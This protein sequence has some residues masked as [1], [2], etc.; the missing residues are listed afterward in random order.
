MFNFIDQTKCTKPLPNGRTNQDM[1][2]IPGTKK[3]A[4]KTSCKQIVTVSIPMPSYSTNDEDPLTI[5]RKEKKHFYLLKKQTLQGHIP[6]S[7]KSMAE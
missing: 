7:S 4:N 2:T 6:W 5:N 3:I 1:K